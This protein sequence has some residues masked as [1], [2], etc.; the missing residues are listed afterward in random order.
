MLIT[1]PTSSQLKEL[2]VT[3]SKIMQM[4]MND[5]GASA[6]VGEV[7]LRREIYQEHT[8]IERHNNEVR[9]WLLCRNMQVPTS[10]IKAQLIARSLLHDSK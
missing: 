3:L 8:L 2:L 10:M 7:N 1:Y 5:T 4:A 6:P 9:Q